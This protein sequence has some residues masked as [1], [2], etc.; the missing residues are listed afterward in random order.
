MSFK[1]TCNVISQ[2]LMFNVINLVQII[3]YFKNRIL[4][5]MCM[6]NTVLM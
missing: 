5:I 1:L 2:I 6:P 3:D 4:A